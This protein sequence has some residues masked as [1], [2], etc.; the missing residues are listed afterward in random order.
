[1]F[2]NNIEEAKFL[3]KYFLWLFLRYRNWFSQIIPTFLGWLLTL[4]LKEGVPVIKTVE[5]YLPPLPTKVTDY[6]T[7]YNYMVYLKGCASDM[8][9]PYVNITLDVGAAMNAYK[10]LWNYP[11]L[12]KNILIHLGDFHFIKENFKAAINI[13]L[14][15]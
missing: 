9:T 10:V 14:F 1:M 7:I 2:K 5:T 11:I 3:P 15:K 13:L 6:E 4:R 8:N 12:F